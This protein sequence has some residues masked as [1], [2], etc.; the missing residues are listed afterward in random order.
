MEDQQKWNKLLNKRNGKYCCPLCRGLLCAPMMLKSCSDAICYDCLDRYLKARHDRCPMC[1]SVY[2][3]GG[4]T[5]N[6]MLCDDIFDEVKELG[7]KDLPEKKE[8]LERYEASQEIRRNKEAWEE[9]GAR[10]THILEFACDC[11]D[12]ISVSQKWAPILSGMSMMGLFY[13]AVK[14]YHIVITSFKTLSFR[15]KN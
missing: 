3:P 13:C 6:R 11:L 7:C 1:Q 2:K 5:Y 10:P 8:W 15:N 14:L 4:H 12:K 9:I